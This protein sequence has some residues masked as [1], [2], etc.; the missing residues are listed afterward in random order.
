MRKKERDDDLGLILKSGEDRRRAYVREWK[1]QR[2]RGKSG[3]VRFYE[4]IA[5]F[6]CCKNALK[7][8]LGVG[9][10]HFNSLKERRRGGLGEVMQHGNTGRARLSQFSEGQKGWETLNQYMQELQET[11]GEPYATRLV[12]EEMGVG[13]RECQNDDV[14]LPS[15]FG[16]R[17]IY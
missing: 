3:V 1:R 6:V 9:R 5:N 8:L 7:N 10:F 17:Q 16:K 14:E 12:R 13:I 15:Y 11:H 2:N 4:V